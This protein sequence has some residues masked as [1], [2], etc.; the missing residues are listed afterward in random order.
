MPEFIVNRNKY[1]GHHEVHDLPKACRNPHYPLPHNRVPLGWHQTC[2]GAI[3]AANA[4]GYSPAD[5][6][7]W[8]A[9][10]CHSR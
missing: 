2:W 3:T 4:N 9:R 1:D 10:A 5:G 6:C 8:C 7:Y